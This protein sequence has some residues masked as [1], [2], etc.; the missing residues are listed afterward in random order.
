MK[1]LLSKLKVERRINR[2][3]G[4]DV[5]IFIVLIFF[6]AFMIL[7]FVYAIVQSIK[8]LEELFLFPPRFFVRNPTLEN[9]FQLGQLSNNLWVPFSKYVF[10]S[11]F[12]TLVTTF[13]HVILASMAAYPLAKMDLPGKN[14]IFGII[15]LA[16]LFNGSVTMLPQYIVMSKLGMINTMSALILPAVGMPLGL[17]LMKQFMEQI[18]DSMIDA[19]QIDGASQ[20]R[21]FWRI[22]MPNVKPAW[23]TLTIFSFQ[24]AWNREGLEFIYDE[25]L[26]VLPTILRQISTSGLARAGVGSAAAVVLMIPPIV[27]FLIVQSNILETMAH[28]GIK[29]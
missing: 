20:F 12:I 18:S 7:P 26:K 29:E 17:F 16:L 24:A 4:G 27:T 19:G 21:I 1:S 15:T 8:P 28:S 23:L 14:W 11:F 2:S 25:S 5:G 9:F 13:F 6:G 10:N 3:T 22:I